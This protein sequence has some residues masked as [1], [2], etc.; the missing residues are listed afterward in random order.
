MAWDLPAV[1]GSVWMQLSFL[2]VQLLGGAALWWQVA[3][4][5]GLQGAALVG[6]ALAGRQVAERYAQ[7]RG[8]LTLLAIGLCPPFQIEG[9]LN[10]HNDL[11]MLA[12][13]VGAG[14][15]YLSGRRPAA[16]VVL[17]LSLGIKL[18]TATA[19]LW[20]LLACL[21]QKRL[22][23]R[24][25]SVVLSG[26]LMAAPSV[27]CYL[28]LWEGAATFQAQYGRLRVGQDAPEDDNSHPLTI[29]RGLLAVIYLALSVVVWRRRAADG[30]LALWPWLAL[31]LIF[32]G[33]GFCYPWYL[34]WPLA[35]SLT[36][37][38]RWHGSLSAACLGFGFIEEIGYSVIWHWW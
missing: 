22:A 33:I 30:W 1:Y 5:K 25:G 11:L 17:G 31:A 14:S 24:L 36:R 38:D 4:L 2:V 34:L 8:N 20:L 35:V 28:S 10:G 19:G 3:G 13:F 23:A 26:L 9:P 29:Q 6:T 15:L 37:W 27:L 7:G 16:S 32:L 18:V 21:R 12:L